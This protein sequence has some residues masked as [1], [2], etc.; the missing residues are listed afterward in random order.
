M[1]VVDAFQQWVYDN[2]N[3]ASDPAFC[4][5]TWA[6]LWERFM[7]GVDWSGLEN[8]KVTGWQRSR[9][10]TA[11]VL[12]RSRAAQLGPCRCGA[13]LRTR[14]GQWQLTAGRSRW[15]DSHTEMFAAAGARFAFDE[16][17]GQ[18]SIS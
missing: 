5:A 13:T 12:C 15:A 3:Q 7:V 17:L 9:I 16:I 4:D 2:P 14:P 18:R 10:S 11:S 1:A 8:E 6:E